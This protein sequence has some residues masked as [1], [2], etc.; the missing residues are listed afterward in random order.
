MLISTND[1]EEN[2]GCGV[3]EIWLVT[4]IEKVVSEASDDNVLLDKVDMLNSGPLND[5]VELD[6]ADE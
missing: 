4:D 3:V 6:S 1:G 2:E 5:T